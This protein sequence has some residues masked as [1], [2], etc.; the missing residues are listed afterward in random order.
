MLAAKTLIVVFVIQLEPIAFLLLRLFLVLLL[1]VLFQLGVG[2]ARQPAGQ[3]Q[4]VVVLL[5]LALLCPLDNQNAATAAG[6]F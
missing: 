6:T 1:L 4:R 3:E 5:L 2:S